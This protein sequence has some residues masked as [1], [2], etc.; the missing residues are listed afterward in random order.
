MSD[1]DVGSGDGT[2]RDDAPT[3]G[4]AG[5][6][7]PPRDGSPAGG[8]P[9]HRYDDGV[10][11]IDTLTAGMTSVTAGYLLAA[12]RPTLIECGPALSIANVVAG[13]RSLGMDPADLAYLVLTHI[14]LDHAG[15]AGDIADAFPDATIVVSE[16]GARH[17]HDPE[18]LNRS[19]AKVYGPLFDRVYGACTPIESD[20]ITAVADGDELDLGA[21]RR[22]ELMYT[23]GHAKHHIGIHDLQTGAIFSGDS[24]GVKLPG[25]RALRPATPPAD[26][27]LEA[28][29][30]SIA[31]YRER[32]PERVYLAHYGP[33]DPPDEALSDA[34]ERLRLWASVAEAAYLEA[35]DATGAAPTGTELDH[36]AETLHRRFRDEVD[37]TALAT[38]PDAQRRLEL[39]NDTRSNAAGLLRY[40]Q[41]RDAGTLTDVG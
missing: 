32:A 31:R 11:A 37:A 36:V 41:R 16:V 3:G 40:F 2:P 18:R 28:A 4:G 12:E 25:M 20:R 22:L 8:P 29:L 30:A 17:L 15:G 33:V 35:L 14:H 27:H 34:D 9:I 5:P 6:E 26:F 38:D 39:L 21:G 23:P 7:P 24:V 10:I 1:S 13:L 19:S